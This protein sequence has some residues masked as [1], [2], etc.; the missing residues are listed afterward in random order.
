MNSKLAGVIVGTPLVGDST[1]NINTTRE[2][3]GSG[4]PAPLRSRLFVASGVITMIRLAHFSDIHITASPLGWQLQDWF[5]KRFPGWL[6]F[7]VL[8]RKFRFRHSVT[9]LETLRKTL[10]QDRIDC[11]VFSGDATA[12]GF[13]VEY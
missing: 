12:M 5:N 7:A 11:A 4:F 9:I 10:D 1:R 6:N 3:L 13:E 2:R 8:G